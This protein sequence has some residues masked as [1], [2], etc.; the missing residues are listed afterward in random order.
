MF[1]IKKFLVEQEVLLVHFS[2]N[3][4]RHSTCYPCDLKNAQQLIGTPLSFSTVQVGDLGMH[5]ATN[6]RSA[7]TAGNVGML[8]EIGESASD[9]TVGRRDDGTSHDNQSGGK[10]SGGE[11]VSEESCEASIVNRVSYN[12]WSI[13]NY[14]PIG[15]FVLEPY[16][17][18][19]EVVCEGEEVFGDVKICLSRILSDFPEE[20]IFTLEEGKFKE[21]NRA[22]E[23]WVDIS[24]S[25]I[26]ENN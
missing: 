10:V 14:K 4:N 13:R 19:M 3:M 6:V 17:V 7:T 22:K 23:E 11:S 1:S 24:H 16:W 12:E 15:I 26:F 21:Y 5:Q 20:R 18:W 2:T 25:D 9:D 8:V